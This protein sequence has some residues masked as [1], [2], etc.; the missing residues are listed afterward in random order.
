MIGF[1]IVAGAYVASNFGKPRTSSLTKIESV[2]ADEA[3]MRVFIPTTDNDTDGTEDW[4]DQFV[5]SPAV[6][7]VD[8]NSVTYEPPK[9]LTGQLG[10]SILENLLAIKAA[11]PLAKP[12]EQI[13]TQAIDRLDDI[14]TKDKIY[15]VKDI[16]ISNRTEDEDIRNYGNAIADII[17]T[18]SAND[19][20]NELLLLRDYLAEPEKEGATADLNRLAGVYK[21]YRDSTIAISVPRQF[22][23]QHLDLINVYN[24]MYEDINSMTKAWNDPMVPYIRIKRYKEDVEGLGLALNNIYNAIV[25]YAKVFEM[26]DSAILLINFSQELQ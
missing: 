17:I 2:T 22:V 8:P 7:I 4:R 5:V 11:G 25:P 26:N 13:L 1:A 9:T 16:I 21:D 3:P 20:D 15:D 18:K 10:V 14:A 19:L 24:A 23:K 12:K 6:A